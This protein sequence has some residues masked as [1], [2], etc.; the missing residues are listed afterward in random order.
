MFNRVRK[1]YQEQILRAFK[2]APWRMQT[3]SIAILAVILLAMA[4][5]GGFYLT[6][7]ARAGTAGRDLQMFEQRKTELILQNDELRAA[8]AVQL[9][10]TN[11]AARWRPK[12]WNISR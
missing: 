10:V 12:L 11:L 4:V 6:V 8:L 2:Q 3:Q 7:A 5:L 1:A 9:S